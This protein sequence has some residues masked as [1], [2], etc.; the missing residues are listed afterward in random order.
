HDR[1]Q[2]AAY[3]LIP[4]ELRAET[5]LRIA[6]VM[7]ADTPPDTIEERIFEIVNQF[8]R[9]SH[10]IEATSER[11]R[12]AALNLIAG[13]RAKNSTAYASALTYARAGR[14]LVTDDAWHRNYGLIF[15]LECLLAE[16][17]LLTLEM[18][19]AEGRLS[20]LAQRAQTAHDRA[21]V[22]RLRLAL[23]VALDRF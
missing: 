8:N 4:H 22:T 12:I 18:T 14:G 17:E 13:R 10:L 6:R 16:C 7:A 5:H 9:A 2:E 3:S 20:T 21:V 19:A 1:V 11:E 15:P 23:C